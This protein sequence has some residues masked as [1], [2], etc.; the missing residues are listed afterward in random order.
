MVAGALLPMV[1]RN[2]DT[3]LV[4]RSRLKP[5]TSEHDFQKPQPEDRP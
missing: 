2:L 1:R 5:A 4:R 3:A